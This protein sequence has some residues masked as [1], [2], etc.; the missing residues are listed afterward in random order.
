MQSQTSMNRV[1]TGFAILC[2]VDFD[3]GWVVVVVV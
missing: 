3:D 2:C 1:G